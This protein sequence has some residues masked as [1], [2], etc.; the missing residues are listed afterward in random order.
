[1]T[2]SHAKLN[3]ITTEKIYGTGQLSAYFQ[4][5]TKNNNLS[6]QSFRR[7]NNAYKSNEKQFSMTQDNGKINKTMKSSNHTAAETSVQNLKTS[8]LNQAV[9]AKNAQKFLRVGRKDE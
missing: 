5:K 9:Q 2:S 1:M 6:S 3:N 8:F 4:N 7:P